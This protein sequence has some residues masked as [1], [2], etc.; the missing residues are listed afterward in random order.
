MSLQTSNIY[1]TSI[2]LD[3][4]N[5]TK[6]NDVVNK[7]YVDNLLNNSP[8]V[9]NKIKKS[10]KTIGIGNNSFGSG[11]FI[12]LDQ[13]DLI[14]GLFL[15]AAHCVYDPET[16]ITYIYV[17][18]PITNNWHKI[19]IDYTNYS[20]NV[21]YDGIADIAIVKTGI[22]LTNHPDCYLKLSDENQNIG[23]VC[24]ICGNPL[25]IDAA[26]FVNGIIRDN[27][28]MVSNGEQAVD[29]LYVSAP[30]FQGNS[31]SPIL[32]IKGD[33]IGIL[34]YG[35]P[36]DVLSYESGEPIGQ[37]NSDT[38]SGGANL[39]TIKKSISILKMFKVNKDKKY[40][41]LNWSVPTPDQLHNLWKGNIFLN[42]G[43][44]I[45]QVSELSPFYGILKAQDILLSATYGNKVIDFGTSES[46]RTPGVLLYEY[47]INSI[48]I[49]FLDD[50]GEHNAVVN[51]NK[52]YLDVPDDYDMYMSTA[53]KNKR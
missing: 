1:A 28:H 16:E 19:N 40:L 9:Y 24:Y 31:G 44:S 3:N 30:S 13:S 22:D 48:S 20:G 17:T 32:N 36:L 52:T 33:I 15:T 10:C 45:N 4:N 35:A 51:L 37:V 53:W 43:A 25:G 14:H 27:H 26:S 5:P 7:K 50:Q 47:N 6:D 42:Q 49:K 21:F 34:T 2:Y 12:S 38:L 23:D 46:Q 11:C 18:N 29:T 39:D 8:N 41:G